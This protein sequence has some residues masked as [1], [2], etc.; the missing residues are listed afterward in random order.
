[1]KIAQKCMSYNVACIS[2]VRRIYNGLYSQI[3]LIWVERQPERA[4][5]TVVVRPE[6]HT[7]KLVSSKR[8]G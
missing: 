2:D 5:Y 6:A 1:M 3:R 4:R 8:V 7:L